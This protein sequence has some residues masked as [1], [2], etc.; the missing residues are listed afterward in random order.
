LRLIF[1][2]AKRLLDKFERDQGYNNEQDRQGNGKL[3]HR[4][5]QAPP[6]P[7]HGIRLTEDASQPPAA[8]LK[9]DNQYQGYGQYYLSDT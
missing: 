7:V 8:H 4:F 6:G 9:Q 2:R 1:Y 3:K 5:F